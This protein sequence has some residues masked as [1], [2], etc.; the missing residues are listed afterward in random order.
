[1]V[2]FHQDPRKGVLAKG[3]FAEIRRCLSHCCL[4]IICTAA[5]PPMCSRPAL[6]IVGLIK[7][8]MLFQG[9]SRLLAASALQNYLQACRAQVQHSPRQR[10]KTTCA[11]AGS[12]CADYPA[13]PRN[14]LLCDLFSPISAIFRDFPRLSAAFLQFARLSAPFIGGDLA[15]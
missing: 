11:A 3:M 1:M 10:W 14:E 9:V 13:H 12:V 15:Q 2:L 5:W 8:N 7:F 6:S 4:C